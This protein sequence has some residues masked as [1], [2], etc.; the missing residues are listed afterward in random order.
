MTET[1]IEKHILDENKLVKE[2]T[3]EVR[4]MGGGL[5]VCLTLLSMLFDLLKTFY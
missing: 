1:E 2:Q 3:A 4:N 5:T